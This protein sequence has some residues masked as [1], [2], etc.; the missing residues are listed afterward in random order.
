MKGKK[1]ENEKFAGAWYT[2]SL[3]AF[4]NKSG[5]G[6]QAATSHCLGQNFAKMFGI[7]FSDGNFFICTHY[8]WIGF[9][10]LLM[11]VYQMKMGRNHLYGKIPGDYQHVLWE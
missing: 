10:A 8:V 5:R 11:D 7:E 3:E 4:A 6:I 2:T 9:V 1:S